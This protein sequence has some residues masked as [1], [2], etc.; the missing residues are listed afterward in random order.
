MAAAVAGLSLLSLRGVLA[1]GVLAP[2]VATRR[3]RGL[4]SRLPPLT[5]A[6][7]RTAAHFA[8]LPDPAPT[9]Y[10]ER[11]AG[12]RPCTGLA[13]PLLPSRIRP[14]SPLPYW[15]RPPALAG[16]GL[17]EGEGLAPSCSAPSGRRVAPAASLSAGAE[18]SGGG[19]GLRQCPSPALCLRR[20]RLRVSRYSLGLRLGRPLPGCFRH[21][22]HLRRPLVDEVPF[23]QPVQ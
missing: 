4:W 10:G 21:F 12:A 20:F 5:A 9:E 8:F 3:C 19:G 7:R 13:F 11:Q 6:A 23:G 1:P 18:S 2:G 17:R 16:V 14:A 22:R 15:Q